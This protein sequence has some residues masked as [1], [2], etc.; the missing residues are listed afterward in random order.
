[1]KALVFGAPPDPAEMRPEPADEPSASCSRSRSACTRCP[2]RTRSG[3]D[4]VV[5]RPDTRG[6][7]R[8]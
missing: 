7:L 6:G 2:T 3:P 8:I 5:T 4:W 1:M